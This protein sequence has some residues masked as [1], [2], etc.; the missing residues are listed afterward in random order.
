METV[1]Q[2]CSFYNG[3]YKQRYST[4]GCRRQDVVARVAHA[5]YVLWSVLRLC[6]RTVNRVL[7]KPELGRR[8]ANANARLAGV[9]CSGMATF[10]IFQDFNIVSCFSL[11]VDVRS[12]PL[13]EPVL[14]G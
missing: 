4:N 1:S 5:S 6:S 7:A 14:I 11:S 13:H 3:D 12:D 9:R 8:G 2:P 10:G